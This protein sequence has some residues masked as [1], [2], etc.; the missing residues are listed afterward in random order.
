VEAAYY[1]IAETNF[2]GKAT[3]DPGFFGKG[4]YFSQFPRYNDYYITNFGDKGRTQA[5][6]MSWVVLGAAYPVTQ[7]GF[8]LAPETLYGETCAAGSPCRNAQSPLTPG[9][10]SELV[11]D[12]DSHYVVVKDPS[13]TCDFQPCP[14]DEEP[15]GDEI[16][17]PFS[18]PPEMAK[19]RILPS[20][21]VYFKRRRR[22]LLWLD[23][24]P[25]GNVGIV[26]EARRAT[27]EVGDEVM[28]IQV[29][30]VAAAVEWLEANPGMARYPEHLFRILS[31]RRLLVGEVTDESGERRLERT[32]GLLHWLETS[33]VWR[34]R[35]VRPPHGPCY[36]ATT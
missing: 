25:A 2:A 29:E 1:S 15:D 34:W 8:P 21:V 26:E 32:A 24:Q 31:N 3:L 35:Q 10:T 13:E 16:V 7:P 17:I 30:S 18:D 27:R 9:A 11:A 19:A 4:F 22:T 6:L 28:V 5:V 12:H 20:V 33:D 36:P 23:D 14:L